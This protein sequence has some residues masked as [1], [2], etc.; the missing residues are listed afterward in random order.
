MVEYLVEVKYNEVNFDSG[1]SPETRIFEIDRI[2]CN[3]HP[4]SMSS[5]ENPESLE[6]LINYTFIINPIKFI[7]RV[8]KL[9]YVKSIEVKKC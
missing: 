1:I 9:D 4:T 3:H 6:T 5:P 7:K 8:L 2:V